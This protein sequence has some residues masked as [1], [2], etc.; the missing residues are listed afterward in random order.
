MRECADCMNDFDETS[1][2]FWKYEP[3][4][5]LCD[6]CLTERYEQDELESQLMEEEDMRGWNGN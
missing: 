5:W 6:D 2:R 4:V 3:G 1:G